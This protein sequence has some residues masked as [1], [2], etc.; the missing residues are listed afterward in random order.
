MK[1]NRSKIKEGDY[2]MVF[3][4]DNWTKDKG[5]NKEFYKKAKILKIYFY[6]S[7]IGSSDWV[8]DV[9]FEDSGYISHAHFLSAIKQI[10]PK[11]Q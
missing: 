2:A 4:S 10:N 5:D 3:D 1:D 7:V 9:Q 11:H 6:H 8:A